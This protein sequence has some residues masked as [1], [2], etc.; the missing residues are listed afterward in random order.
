MWVNYFLSQEGVLSGSAVKQAPVHA[1]VPNQ[2]V[3]GA[4]GGEDDQQVEEHVGIRMS[5]LWNK[6]TNSN[7]L[8]I[9]I[10]N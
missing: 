8:H 9:Y 1:Q 5:L 3:Q 7:K 4:D 10:L 2:C 6:N